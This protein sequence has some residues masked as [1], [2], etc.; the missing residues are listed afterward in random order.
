[1]IQLRFNI[2]Y[3]LK[4]ILMKDNDNKNRTCKLEVIIII[5]SNLDIFKIN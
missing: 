5:R 3:H 4:I 2:N 1:M